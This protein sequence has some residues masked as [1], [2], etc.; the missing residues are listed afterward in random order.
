MRRQRYARHSSPPACVSLTPVRV[1]IL[2][3]L[4]ELQFLSFAADREA[5]LPRRAAG[6]VRKERPTAHALAF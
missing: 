1:R 2:C 4:A 5:L 6:T 3:F